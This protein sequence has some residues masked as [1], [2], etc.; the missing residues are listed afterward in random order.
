MLR[1]HKISV[2]IM[3]ILFQ[4][5][6]HDSKLTKLMTSLSIRILKISFWLGLII[7]EVFR[8]CPHTIN[9]FNRDAARR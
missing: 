7:S 8:N 6:S 5:R 3:I 9:L 2:R 1:D 4:G